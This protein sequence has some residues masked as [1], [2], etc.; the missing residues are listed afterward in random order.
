MRLAYAKYF[1][2]YVHAVMPDITPPDDVVWLAATILFYAIIIRTMLR[3]TLYF[4][5]AFIL[6]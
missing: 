5:V 4:I 3:E 1:R 6:F 2:I